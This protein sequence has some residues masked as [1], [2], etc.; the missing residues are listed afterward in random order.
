MKTKRVLQWSMILI[1]FFAGLTAFSCRKKKEPSL[2]PWGNIEEMAR[3]VTIYRDTYGVPHIFGPTDASV[4]FGFM[5]A[6]AEDRF[7][8]IERAYIRALGR[9]AEVTGE[10]GFPGDVFTRALE[11]KNLS[12]KEYQNSSRKIRDLCEAAADALN[13]Y[14]RQNPETKPLL[15]NKM[16]PWY[17][18]ASLRL[19]N[20]GIV[21]ILGVDAEKAADFIFPRQ[22]NMDKGSNMWAVAPSKSSSG[23]AML[24]LNPHMRLDVPYEC[25]LHSEQGWNLSGMTGYGIGITPVMGHN[26]SLGWSHT[27]NFPDAA[28]VY[29]E[30]FDHPE[31][32]LAYRYGNG[33][34]NATEWTEVIRV[35]T[36]AG[37]KERNVTLRKTH[38]GPI[39][40][41]KEGKLLSLRIAKHEEGGLLEQWYRMG[42]AENLEE[43]RS[44][45]S[46]CSLIYH[47]TMYADREGNIYYVYSGAI[48]LRDPAFDWTKPVDGTDPASEWKGFHTLG[49]LPQVLNP[50]SGWIQNC[51]S[52]PFTT[53]GENKGNPEPDDY[54]DYMTALER[55]TPRAQVSR[56]ILASKEHFTFQDWQSSAFD[57]YMIE[58]EEKIK[59]LKKEWNRFRRTRT[60]WDNK[61]NMVLSE[62]LSWDYRAAID[63]VPATLFIL[64]YEKV[65][66]SGE[67]AEE[68]D[69]IPFRG[70][71]A[72]EEVIQ[73]LEDDFGT[74]RVAWGDINRLQR[75]DPASGSSFSDDEASLP[76]AGA[77]GGLGLVFSF[78]SRQPAG[79]KLRY[80]LSG[81]TYVSVAEFG[82]PIVRKS[83][84]PFGQ[85]SDPKS[86]HFFDQAP[87][88]AKGQLKPVWFTLEEIEANLERSYH[89]GDEDGFQEEIAFDQKSR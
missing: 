17:I 31:N 7:D 6:R 48:P 44:A 75:R 15:L 29:A 69:N 42:K 23:S 51:N 53:T 79:L 82:D 68:E 9:Y 52:T 80:G 20:A 34:R 10:E 47:N 16:E 30:A 11:I 21:E 74:W 8:I 81:H 18:L 41:E 39:I 77:S 86:S 12:I 78:Y 67:K 65:F 40:G 5:Y 54:P 13:Y 37:M 62:I 26:E 83:V 25:H 32:P 22:G 84:I 33:Y 3:S 87:L 27:V 64:W 60:S 72:L 50:E 46:A 71:R 58:A 61:L 35:K 63:S 49:E 56:Q 73:E 14:L 59:V 85:N 24:F 76:V 36:E 38:H 4:V 89:P 45:I 70:I 66:V 2:D 19:F 57:T 43:F 28:D 88:Y 1:I 55:D